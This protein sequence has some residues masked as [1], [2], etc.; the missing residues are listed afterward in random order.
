MAKY[1]AW[2]EIHN[3]G[4]T[5]EVTLPN[6]GKRQV[7]KSRNIIAPGEVVVKAKSNLSDEEWDHLVATGSI[8]P[9]PYPE[10]AGENTSP[11]QAVM[12]RLTK[13]TGEIDPNMMMELALS[14][15]PPMNPPADEVPEGV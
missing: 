10:E 7:V 8:R 14:N 3:G 4:E 13:G 9:Y 15:P 5:T 11:T 1:Y 2:S 6:G 12:T